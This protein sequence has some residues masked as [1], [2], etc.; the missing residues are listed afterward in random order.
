MNEEENK[1]NEVNDNVED[2]EVT[3]E[4]NKVE[5]KVE[6][7]VYNN[8]ISIESEDAMF[9]LINSNQTKFFAYFNKAKKVS[10]ILMVVFMVIILTM[11][12]VGNGNGLNIGIALVLVVVYFVIISTYSKKTKSIINKDSLNVLDEY[13]INIDSYVTS[14][15]A[16]EDVKFN[17]EYKLDENIFSSLGICKDIVS[18]VGRDLIKGKVCGNDFVAGDNCIKTREKKEDGTE[19]DYIVFLGKLFVINVE[20]LVSDGRA[21]IYLKGKGANGPTD[22]SDLTKV[23]LLGEKFDVYSSCDLS[24]V[25]TDNVKSLLSTYEVND[26]LVDMFISI[27]NKRIAFGFSYNDGVM[28]VPLTDPLNKEAL[29]EYKKDV[30]LMVEILKSLGK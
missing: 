1:L 12:F 16:F 15:E 11:M 19:Q 28:V 10:S 6:S 25:L 26:N 20:N 17:R 5:E 18:V 24:N 22:I 13:F 7:E 4:V 23:D 30:E 29:L 14:N 21:I 3:E 9:D 2:K 27:D 8:P